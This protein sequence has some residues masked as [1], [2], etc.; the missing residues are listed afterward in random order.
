MVVI[1]QHPVVAVNSQ[2]GEE[3][4]RSGFEACCL[5]DPSARDRLDSQQRLLLCTASQSAEPFS[6]ALAL[7]HIERSTGKGRG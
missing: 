3:C 6:L 2:L 4:L 1:H 5:L 7:S